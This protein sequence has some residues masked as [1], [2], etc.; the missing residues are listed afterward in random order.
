M[1]EYGIGLRQ[2]TEVKGNKREID[3]GDH[4]TFRPVQ[5]VLKKGI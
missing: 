4:F 1:P 2:T 3:L 5:S